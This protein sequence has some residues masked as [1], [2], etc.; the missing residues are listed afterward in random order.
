VCVPHRSQRNLGIVLAPFLCF[1]QE[2]LLRGHDSTID[3]GATNSLDPF[4]RSR[5]SSNNSFKPSQN[6]LG[7][8]KFDLCDLDASQAASRRA[9]RSITARPAAQLRKAVASSVPAPA[10]RG[11]YL[12]FEEAQLEEL[13]RPLDDDPS[14]GNSHPGSIGPADH[15]LQKVVDLVVQPY[16]LVSMPTNTACH[17]QRIRLGNHLVRIASRTIACATD[18][19]ADTLRS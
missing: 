7:G 11:Q 17:Q 16:W 2:Q 18:A 8:T 14:R 12:R 19:L 1:P 15:S 9:V 4:A 13:E 3:R 10:I 5:R 6:G